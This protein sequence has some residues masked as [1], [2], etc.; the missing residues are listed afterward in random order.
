[1]NQGVMFR[2]LFTGK[3][4]F[5]EYKDAAADV[6]A[7]IDAYPQAGQ[8][9]VDL[10]GWSYTEDAILTSGAAKLEFK[11]GIGNFA[12]FLN[13]AVS[14]AWES[15]LEA[16]DERGILVFQDMMYGTDGIMP[17]AAATPNQEAELRQGRVRELAA[18]REVL[19]W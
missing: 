4:T 16:C 3:T 2:E 7:V 8:E 10:G 1:M 6:K 9:K 5:A 12:K 14:K 19:P 11:S 15:W 17:G 18:V 13:G